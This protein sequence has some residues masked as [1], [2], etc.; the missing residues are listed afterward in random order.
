MEISRA[1]ENERD[2]EGKESWRASVS[3]GSWESHSSWCHWSFKGMTKTGEMPQEPWNPSTTV[4]CEAFEESDVEM[5]GR[6]WFDSE[7]VDVV[8]EERL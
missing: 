1:E 7:Q 6:L 8:R 2:V 3:D 4:S 5:R